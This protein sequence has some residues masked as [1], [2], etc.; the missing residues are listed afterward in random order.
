MKQKQIILDVDTTN[1][2]LAM[3]TMVFHKVPKIMIS[4]LP[5]IDIVFLHE[6]VWTYL[7]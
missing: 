3:C 5:A 2:E 1:C 7:A 6:D 4:I